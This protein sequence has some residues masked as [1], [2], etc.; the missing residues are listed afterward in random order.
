MS[1]GIKL[2]KQQQKARAQRSLAI[3]FGLLAFVV[4]V[5]LVTF[6]RAS[7]MAATVGGG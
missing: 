7:Q 6:Y 2:T 5:F 3:G 4:V 1:D